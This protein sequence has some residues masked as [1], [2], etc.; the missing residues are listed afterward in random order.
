MRFQSFR[1]WIVSLSFVFAATVVFA[2]MPAS[3]S[4][5][6]DEQLRAAH[7][8]LLQAA[9]QRDRDA[10]N[11]LA[12]DDLTW[13]TPTGKVAG[14]AEMLD[15]IP[16]AP[17]EVTID[18]TRTFG[19]IALVTG[20]ASFE[21]GR[22]LRFLQEWVN[23]DGQWR[24]MAHEGTLIGSSSPTAT[25]TSGEMSTSAMSGRAASSTK[26]G[27]NVAPR[28]NSDDE[29]AVWKAQVDLRDAF[30]K[31]DSAAYGKLT[32]DDYIR[33]TVDGQQQGKAEFLRTVAQNAGKSKGHL[34]MSDVQL[35]VNGDTARVVAVISGTLPGGEPQPPERIT[36]IFVKQDGRWKQAGMAFAPIREQ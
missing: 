1:A 4:S 31:A 16:T 17:H 3:Q 11:R 28:L 22:Q 12:A 24:V 2:Q 27:R 33:V 26:A 35:A 21:D 6:G 23:Q 25:G 19:K 9:Q 34:E 32:T 18:E 5:G 29:R 13:V 15:A 30:L 14:K 10:I 20:V 8:Q 7:Q 36:R